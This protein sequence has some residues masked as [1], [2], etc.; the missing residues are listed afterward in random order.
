MVA[1][2]SELSSINTAL[3]DLLKRVSNIAEEFDREKREDVANSLYEV[4]RNLR[5]ATRKLSKTIG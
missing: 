4:E 2:I 1:S 3:E 5:T